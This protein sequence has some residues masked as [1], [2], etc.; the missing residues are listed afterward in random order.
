MCGRGFEERTC[1]ED[2]VAAHHGHRPLCGRAH[3]RLFG[4]RGLGPVPP[5]R[6]DGRGK[7][8]AHRCDH[9][10]PV[11]GRG[12]H[13]GRVEGPPAFQ[14]HFGFGSLGGGP[15]VRGGDGHLPGDTYPRVHAGGQ[16][17]A[18]QFEVDAHSRRGGSGRSGR[19]AHGGAD[20]VGSARR[21]LRDSGNRGPRQGS[22]PADDR[23]PAGQVLPVPQRHVGCSRADPA[24][25]FRHADLRGF[26]EGSRR[27]GRLVEARHRG[28]AHRRRR[29]LRARAVAE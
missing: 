23:P 27:C 18:A 16:E 8:H 10:R 7:V 5:G 28:A 15:G 17:V 14:P 22:V 20:R 26:H 13:E 19:V 24:R 4:L 25:H 29:R 9:L 1:S 2:S 11:R 12:A 6:A 3:G 21:G